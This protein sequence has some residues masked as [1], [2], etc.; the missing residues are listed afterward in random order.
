MNLT[1]NKNIHKLLTHN[2]IIKITYDI[3]IQNNMSNIL[4][5]NFP[6]T[7]IQLIVF[8]TSFKY[9]SL[10]SVS[11]FVKSRYLFFQCSSMF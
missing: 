10:D 2:I 4:D 5:S 9:I 11:D 3:N 1:Y 6:Y 7:L 8:L